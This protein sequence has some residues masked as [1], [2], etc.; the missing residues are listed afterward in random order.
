MNRKE[1]AT[2]SLKARQALKENLQ[3]EL[4]KRKEI[5]FAYIHGSFVSSPSF[6]DV[7]V[8]VFVDSQIVSQDRAL[9]YELELSALLKASYPIDVRLLNYAPPGFQNNVAHSGELLFSRDDKALAQFL[10]DS[11]LFMLENSYLIRESAAALAS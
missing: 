8:A 9:D 1:Y 2:I 10:E 11:S 7:D 4:L 6:R 3:S 5:I